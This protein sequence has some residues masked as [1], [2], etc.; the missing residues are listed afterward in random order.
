MAK[1][2]RYQSKS[3]RKDGKID[4][5]NSEDAIWSE[6]LTRQM[7]I[8]EGK[9]CNEYLNGLERLALPTDRAPQLDEISRVLQDT[10]GW[11]CEPVAALIDFDTFFDLLSRKRF[12]VA[13][14][15]RRQEDFDYLQE[16]DFFHEVFGHCAMLTHPAFAAFTE[17]YGKLGKS[18]SKE[19][20]RYLARL[21]WFTVEF[22]LMNSKEQGQRI[23]GGGILSSPK[24]TEYAFFSDEPNRKP[25]NIVRYSEL[26]TESISFRQCIL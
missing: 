25:F 1:V 9:A 15:L 4:W 18:A 17:Q 2:S 11:Q 5:S 26:P 23:Y 14:F 6:L 20:R 21:Y 16:P 24:E 3:M 13:T 7:D 19:E 22:G 10:T 8:I 12:P